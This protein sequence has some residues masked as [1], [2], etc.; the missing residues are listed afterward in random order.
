MALT[1]VMDIISHTLAVNTSNHTPLLKVHRLPMMTENHPVTVVAMG[2]E[3]L[4]SKTRRILPQTLKV[5]VAEKNATQRVGLLLEEMNL[6]VKQLV[7]DLCLPV[8]LP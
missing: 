3:V 8:T 1:L 2:P 6:Y 4:V 7:I 5:P